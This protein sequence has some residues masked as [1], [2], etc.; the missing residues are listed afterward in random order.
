MTAL[1]ILLVFSFP[2]LLIKPLLAQSYYPV[3]W[4]EES[5]VLGAGYFKMNWRYISDV[6]QLSVYEDEPLYGKKIYRDAQVGDMLWVAAGPDTLFRKHYH[7]QREVYLQLLYT[8]AVSL[9]K[10]VGELAYFV[11]Y[12]GQLTVLDLDNPMTSLKAQLPLE[13]HDTRSLKRITNR[14]TALL[15]VHQLNACFAEEEYRWVRGDFNQRLRIGFAY[16]WMDEHAKH[17]SAILKGISFY[18]NFALQVPRS[19]LT[20]NYFPWAANT[21]L[22]AH[23]QFR[24]LRQS[25]EQSTRMDGSLAVWEEALSVTNLYAFLGLRLELA[26]QRNIQPYIGGGLASVIPLYFKY[27]GYFKDPLLSFPGYPIREELRNGQYLDFGF[28]TEMGLNIRLGQRVYVG[29]SYRI[30]GLYQNWRHFGEVQRINRTLLPFR[31]ELAPYDLRY[32]QAQ[33][34][35]GLK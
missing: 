2:L 16:D 18:R 31:P 24:F 23:G 3:T 28:Y 6:D 9:Y 34:A 5:G 14:A 12:Q 27:T 17:R 4:L 1:R 33:I 35:Y 11:S 21:W 8:G 26:S 15:F 10:V 7:G 19:S 32:L 30:E 29:M 20:V 13:C 22:S 25:A